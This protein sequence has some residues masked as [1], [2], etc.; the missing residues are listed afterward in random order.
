ML[1]VTSELSALGYVDVYISSTD[2]ERLGQQLAYEVETYYH[3]PPQTQLW[4]HFM[5]KHQCCGGAGPQDFGHSAWW[6]VT[7]PQVHGFIA[8][9]ACC[10]EQGE[11]ACQTLEHVFEQGCAKVLRGW[12]VREVIGVNIILGSLLV[13]QTVIALLVYRLK[14]T[15]LKTFEL[16]PL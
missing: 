9:K 15:L 1:L 14:K 8:P 6:N 12:I 10:R 16:Y 3:V 2:T 4:D 13:I 11:G 7:M 5:R